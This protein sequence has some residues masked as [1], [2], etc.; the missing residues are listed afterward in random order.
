MLKIRLARH[1][2]KKRPFFRIVLTEHT[3]PAQ[4]GYILVL[5]TYDPILH[6]LEVNVDQ[7][8][9]WINKWAQ[10]SE[11][12]AKLLFK[13][14]NDELFKKYFKIIE[15]NRKPKKEKEE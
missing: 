7:V 4:S 12:V 3:K 11:R 15:R 8:K 14:T 13:E 1:G 6:K 9:E 5:G 2:R 10:P